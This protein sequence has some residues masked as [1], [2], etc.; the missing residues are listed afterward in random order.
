MKR[1][2]ARR[3]E[4]GVSLFPFLAVLICTMGA[5]IVLLVLVVQQARVQA[6][7]IC[8]QMAEEQR[9]QRAA[10]RLQMQ[11]EEEDFRWQQQI[12]EQQRRE[13]TERLSDRRLELGHLEDHIRRL[14]LRW[15]QL[16]AELAALQIGGD[17]RVEDREAA[18]RELLR[19][20]AELEAE[21]QRL[22]DAREQLSRR[23]R[24]FSIIPYD[25][26]H[27]T[28][29]R[30]IYIECRE[31][32]ITIQ[33]EGIVL[34]PQDFAGPLGPGNPLDAALRAIRE[35][36]S[37]AEGQ[38]KLGEPYPLLIVRSD[39]AVA[40]SMARSAMA[41]WDDEF[42]YELVGADMS[43][44]FPPSDPQLRGLL[45][46]TIQT[47]RQR[48]ALLA[49]AMPKR[50]SAPSP[51]GFRMAAG[52]TGWSD[53]GEGYGSSGGGAGSASG[54]ASTG[55]ARSGGNGLGTG[56]SANGGFQPGPGTSLAGVGG[57]SRRSS[58]DGLRPGGNGGTGGTGA[59]GGAGG[60][61]G[62]AAN[63][64]G[65]AGMS[66][67]PNA[68][69]GPGGGST[70]G[71]AMQG[72]G[73]AG[74]SAGGLAGHA[75]GAQGAAG[76]Q[77]GSGGQAGS[78]SAAGGSGGAAGGSAGGSA[79]GSAGGS[80]GASAGGASGGASCDANQAAGTA[81]A[82]FTDPDSLPQSI[83]RQRGAN[84]ALPSAASR[85]TGITRPIQVECYADRLVILPDLGDTRDP[86][87]IPVTGP[88]RGSV[89]RFVAGVWSHT[90]RWGMAVAGG[91]WKPVIKVHV[92]PDA[93]DR[94]LE[95]EALLR[96]S[97]IE[98]E[99]R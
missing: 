18:G 94:F 62:S 86:Q 60:G 76:G 16:H 41:N 35:Y 90:E 69:P 52:D 65:T 97:G 31:T 59:T 67:F 19:L 32:G 51:E 25:G 50:F 61:P 38:S 58:G 68:G 14:E 47:A 63:A 74:G 43:L 20:Q 75:S 33:P 71:Q 70:P 45:E 56:N 84:W 12:L 7:T 46:S 28:R 29:R 37:R 73:T 6:D 27:G 39:G 9:E 2:P 80:A 22:A 95:L 34:T 42:G 24:S 53:D 49:A 23:K 1:V 77:T 83:A 11:Q 21:R 78:G 55:D 40:Y 57:E 66:G 13:L 26:P 10:E 72:S 3:A 96:D 98:V 17:D 4:I 99:R 92:A 30:P 8:E 15:Q 89:Q 91:Y 44:E 64:G 36:W 48:Q 87:T 5:L 93:Q 81:S 88:M 79:A 82:Q 85:S 54:R